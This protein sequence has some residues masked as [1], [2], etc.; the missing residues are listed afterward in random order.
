MDIR[1]LKAFVKAAETLNF[2]E[3]AKLVC[4]TQSTFS[5]SIR[6]L[7]DEL[8]IPLFI[9][10]TH[11]VSLTEAGE[12]LLP[13]AREVLLQTEN[14]VHRIEDLKAM[15]TGELN[16]G[17]T[18]SF[19]IMTAEAVLDFAKQYPE[20]RLNII[21][22]TMEELMEMLNKREVD[23][24]LSYQSETNNSNIE[25]HLLYED[26]LA[27]IVKDGHPLQTKNEVCISDIIQYPMILPA[28]GF[29]A[30]NTF[31]AVWEA[32][33]KPELNIRMEMNLVTPI[34][35]LVV[36]GQYITVLSK[37]AAEDYEGI[38]AIPFSSPHAKMR[39][40]FHLLKNSYH[41]IAIKEF[42]RTLRET[43]ILRR[44]VERWN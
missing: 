29:Q 9:R 10:N 22:K 38:R 23:F 25:S 27:L 31:D 41:K 16:I 43:N 11:E 28:V 3:A 30:R 37:S 42:I 20:I 19:S 17:V 35:R 44:R 12:E 2:S 14:C 21:Y 40:A 39:G 36:Q 32:E 1:Q 7:E 4:V 34:V 8:N 26:T 15:K 5:Q 18:H 6:Q 24:V 33:N 13:Y